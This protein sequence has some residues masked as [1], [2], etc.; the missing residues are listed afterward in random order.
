MSEQ[1]TQTPGTLQPSTD[2]IRRIIVDALL[3]GLRF[4]ARLGSRARQNLQRSARDALPRRSPTHEAIEIIT[5]G[6]LSRA[7]QRLPYYAA[8]GAASRP[9]LASALH[10]AVFD[11][12]E[13]AAAVLDPGTDEWTSLDPDWMA[14]A[15][16]TH[17]RGLLEV[18]DAA[19]IA[20]PGATEILAGADPQGC[21]IF[22]GKPGPE[23]EFR[24][25]WFR[26]PDGGRLQLA[27]RWCGG[28]LWIAR[29]DYGD[30]RFTAVTALRE[31]YVA[32]LSALL[33]VAS[34]AART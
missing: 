1:K 13:H 26:D 17:L 31:V 8:E 34:R 11:G 16:R 6:L 28:R 7:A 3:H 10:A 25:D 5:S 15:T 29:R 9:Y 24:T 14:S 4:G 20:I 33:S 19:G 2:A 32:P 12:I 30:E 21:R 22:V 18:L 27:V 23:Q